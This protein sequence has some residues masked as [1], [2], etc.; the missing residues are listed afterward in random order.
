MQA[1][2]PSVSE[3]PRNDLR[4]LERQKNSMESVSSHKFHQF[5]Q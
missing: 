1:I 5:I 3:M 2:A 4:R